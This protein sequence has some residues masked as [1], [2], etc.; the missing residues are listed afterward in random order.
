MVRKIKPVSRF[1]KI[2]EEIDRI[3]G[4]VFFHKKDFFGLDEGWIP[5]VDIYEKENEIAIETEIPGVSQK[6]ITILLHS[7]RIEI[8][9]VKRENLRAAKVRYLRLERESGTFRRIVYLPAS[10]VPEKTKAI[11]SNGILT[12][13][14]RKPGKKKEKEVMVKIQETRENSGRKK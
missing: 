8:R 6:D 7:N 5:H 1:T 12:I 10:V 11:L 2:E 14:L 13:I 9:G 3:I 4:E